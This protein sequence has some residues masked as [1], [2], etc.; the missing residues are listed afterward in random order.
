MGILTAWWFPEVPGSPPVWSKPSHERFWW[1]VST[2]LALRRE[3]RTEVFIVAEESCPITRHQVPDDGSV[4][5]RSPPG[6]SLSLHVR[7]ACFSMPAG[8][9]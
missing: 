8:M 5:F 9:A 2:L 6:I 7:E 1:L 3:I 4:L